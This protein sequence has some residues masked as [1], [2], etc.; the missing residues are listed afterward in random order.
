MPKKKSKPRSV[1]YTDLWDATGLGITDYAGLMCVT[2]P[3]VY[4]Y[5]RKAGE[6]DKSPY[7]EL[8]LLHA[9]AHP[10]FKLVKR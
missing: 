4:A 5:T 7:T 6:I 1:T 9:G 10:F 2:L 8:A 3:T